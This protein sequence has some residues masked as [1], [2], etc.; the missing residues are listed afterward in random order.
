MLSFGRLP[1]TSIV[2]ALALAGSALFAACAPASSTTGAA[3][4]VPTGSGGAAPTGADGGHGGAAVG[5]AGGA[6]PTGTGGHGGAAG[7]G[8]ATGCTNDADCAGKPAGPHCDTKTGA[9]VA[10]LPA[11]DDCAAGQFCDPATEA[12]KAGCKKDGDC[13]APLVC[14]AQAHQCVGCVDDA[15]CGAGT[16]CDGGNCV[17][18]CSPKHDCLAGASCCPD[19]QC[20]D[21]ASDVEH[22]GLCSTACKAPA[23]ADAACVGGQCSM[24]ACDASF[25]D[26]DGDPSN[27]CEQNTLADGPCLCKPGDTQPCYD[28]APGTQNVGPCKAGV[29]TCAPSGLAW[30]ACQGEVLPQPEICGNKIDDDC[31]GVVDDVPDVDGDGWTACDGD[32]CETL[33]QCANPA[34]VNPGAFEVAGDGVD[35]DCDGKIDDALGACDQ[36]LASNS[37]NAIDFAKAIDLCQQTVE[38]PASLKDKRWGVISAALLKADGTAGAAAVSHAIRPGF[39]AKI[40]PKMGNQLAILSTGAAAAEGNQSPAYVSFQA[41]VT[42]SCLLA[43]NCPDDTG[44]ASPLPSDWLAANGGKLPN[45]PGCPA[46]NVADPANPAQNPMMLKVRVRVPTNAKSFN[47]ATYFLSAEYPEWVCSPYN[48]FF[49]TLLDSAFVPGPGEQPNPKDKNLAFYAPSPNTVYP[50]G[51]NLAFG[52]TG[53]FSVCKNGQTGCASGATLGTTSKCVSSGD[54]NGTGFEILDPAPTFAPDVGYCG[55]NNQLGGGTGWL[56]TTGNVKPGETM[57][58]RFAVWDTSDPWYDS[59]VLLDAFTWSLQATQPG[60]HQ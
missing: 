40:V 18:G 45:A 59:L 11:S 54:L 21:L 38:S 9:C 48:D 31:D 49:V 19:A 43:G 20:H 4:S 27:G 17:P 23:N 35:N 7:N 37:A 34:L 47:V 55:A 58:I 3:T 41:P 28:G 13:K 14:D 30:G 5:G 29:Q 26:C 6:T 53:L 46:P 57:E 33:Q 8:G 36:G 15:Q 32:C 51:V 1:L 39:G 52:D 16:V 2:P 22:C 50:V 56:V 60:T 44:T 25:A 42:Q 10:C 12:C 24:G